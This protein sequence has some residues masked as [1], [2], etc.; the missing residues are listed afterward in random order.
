MD[1]LLAAINFIIFY[2][3]EPLQDHGSNKIGY[4][5][6]SLKHA[7]WFRVTR[8]G[9]TRIAGLQE[10]VNITWIDTMQWARIAIS[11]TLAIAKAKQIA[12]AL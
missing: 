12:A 6:L 1:A 10:N 7:L 4:S 8:A 9:F 11:P 5:N 2:R 3:Q